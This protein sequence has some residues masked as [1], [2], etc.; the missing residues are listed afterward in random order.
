MCQS[1]KLDPSSPQIKK[2]LETKRSLERMST[3][4]IEPKSM[5]V[6]K[7]MDLFKFVQRK[8]AMLGLKPPEQ[9]SKSHMTFH[10]ILIG[11]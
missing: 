7:M 1:S 4:E 5:D 3:Q 10:E 6:L 11:L 8:M 9:H 2:T